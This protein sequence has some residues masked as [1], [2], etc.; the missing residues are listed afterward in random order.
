MKGNVTS[1]AALAA[2]ALALPVTAAAQMG[3]GLYEYTIR[4]NV[5][6]GPANIPPQTMQRCLTDK[7][8]AGAQGY[9]VPND[10]TSDCKVRD[11]TQS[12]GQ[13]AYKL[14]CTKPQKIDGAVK[15]TA[16]AASIAMDM[17]M[18]IEGIPGPLTQSITA[19]RLG[20]CKQ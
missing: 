19:R 18:T 8:V 3:A 2:L 6:G 13:F 7:D 1:A 17:T 20:D 11:L 12:G 16:T 14:A 9:E 5:P 4:M 10:P 15:G